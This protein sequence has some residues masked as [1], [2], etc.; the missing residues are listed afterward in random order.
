M[1]DERLHNY[2]SVN[3]IKWQFSLSRAPW[4]GGQSERIIGIMK[5][6]LHKSI[7]NGMLS[8]KELQEVLVDV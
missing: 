5:S 7:G 2:L 1:K 3:Q 8:W 6:A 4:W